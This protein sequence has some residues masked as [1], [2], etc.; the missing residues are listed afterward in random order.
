MIENKRPLTSY[1]RDYKES[2]E[3]NIPM[4]NLFGLDEDEYLNV[5]AASSARKRL[6]M[7]RRKSPVKDHGGHIANVMPPPELGENINA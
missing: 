2:Q 4:S 3:H 7:K 6:A 1:L 5:Q